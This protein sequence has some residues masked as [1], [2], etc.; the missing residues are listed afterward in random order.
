MKVAGEC[1]C[2]QISYEAEIDPE[3]V[4]LCHCNDCQTFSGSAFRTAVSVNEQD[5]RLLSGNP[6]TYIKT[7]ES[8]N[9]RQQVFC[10]DCGTHIYATSTGAGAKQFGLRVATMK[11]R[12]ELPPTK[13]IWARSAQPWA[14]NLTTIAQIETQ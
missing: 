11:Q 4:R 1:H 14:K 8:G 2:G 13:Q 7:A 10:S 9:R 5:F 6:K 12:N 3:R